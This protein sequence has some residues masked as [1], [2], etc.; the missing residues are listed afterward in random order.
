MGAVAKPRVV[1][2]ESVYGLEVRFQ[3]IR[4]RGGASPRKHL[5]FDCLADFELF[6]MARDG[7]VPKVS[8]DWR[9]ADEGDWVV[10]DADG[11]VAQILKRGG[12][13]HPK[14]SVNCKVAPNGYCR[15]VVGTF[16]TNKRYR[17]DTDFTAHA[18]RYT[19]T[20]NPNA[21]SLRYAMTHRT[22][23]TNKEKK[24]VSTL[25]MCLQQGNGR[26]ESLIIAVKEAG[27]AA[28]DLH[29]TME[30]A[31][32][33][34]Q[35]DRIMKLISEQMADAAEEI[36]L[37]VKFVM[38]GVYELASSA[39]REDVRLSALNQA[40]KYIGM[41][42]EE[43]DTENQLGA[44]YQGFGNKPLTDGKPN[45]ESEVEALEAEFDDFGAAEDVD[46]NE[47]NDGETTK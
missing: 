10:A 25:M 2:I 22:K 42:R 47:T 35:Q 30:K 6:H 3:V 36:G 23:L 14:D 12:L 4:P 33:L 11:G 40:G 37:T 45:G 19:F 39:R 27:Y 38:R 16:S 32:V 24:F 13:K 26:Q 5:V 34:L 17:M 29:R 31:N 9:L 20:N 28:R 43:I 18:N 46:N 1:E 21:Y 44:G 8:P 7:V 15:T 41:E